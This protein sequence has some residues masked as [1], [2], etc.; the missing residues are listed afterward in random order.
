MP[1]KKHL[2]FKKT[3]AKIAKKQGISK[4]ASGAILAS[5]ARKASPAAVKKNPALL[6]V[7]RGVK[8]FVDGGKNN[9]P[10]DTNKRFVLNGPILEPSKQSPETMQKSRPVQTKE[11]PKKLG[12]RKGGKATYSSKTT[13][14]PFAGK[15]YPTKKSFKATKSGKLIS[16]TK[17][18]VPY[19][20]DSKVN[21]T[22][23]YTKTSIDTT[24]Y[25]KGK[26]SFPANQTKY[27]PF[28]SKGVANDL[29][30][31]STRSFDVPRNKVEKTIK[32]MK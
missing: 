3:Q 24:G 23:G 11:L 28:N 16:Y 21:S 27:N 13:Y 17:S 18:E 1:V 32:E 30:P 12:F 4:K 5:A 26:K 9:I 2:G 31:A 6:N 25:S 10:S 14:L 8:K 15:N 7:K 20:D 22:K 29:Y 19:V